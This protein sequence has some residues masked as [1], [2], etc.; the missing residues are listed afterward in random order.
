LGFWPVRNYKGAYCADGGVVMRYVD[1]PLEYGTTIPICYDTISQHLKLEDWMVDLSHEKYSHL[2]ALGEKII[3]ENRGYYLSM[4][5]FGKPLNKQ[6]IPHHSRT[7]LPTVDLPTLALGS[8]LGVTVVV[9]TTY[10]AAKS[11]RQ[12]ASS[13]S[14]AWKGF[15]VQGD[16][17][18]Y[19]KD[20]NAAMQQ[21]LIST[22]HFAP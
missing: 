9:G 11:A 10:L 17:D 4:L 18:D 20:D 15:W 1:L 16:D 6:I 14:N 19:G 21:L 22:N 5:W 2:Y 7:L 8:A 3:D 12:L 13:V